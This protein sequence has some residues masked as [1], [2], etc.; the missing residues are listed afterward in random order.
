VAVVPQ[1]TFL[2]STTIED[3]LALG[4]HEPDAERRATPAC[5]PPPAC[6]PAANDTVAAL[7]LPVR[8]ACRGERG[9]NLSGRADAAPPPWP[10]PVAQG[11]AGAGC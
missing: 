10:A 11:G 3:N 9:I 8:H 1:D 4:F 2:F 5:A 7:P 6:A